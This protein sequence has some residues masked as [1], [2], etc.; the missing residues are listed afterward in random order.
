MRNLAMRGRRE[1]IREGSLCSESRRKWSDFDKN[2]IKIR[3]LE[4]EM[5]KRK[6]DLFLPQA[7]QHPP[8]TFSS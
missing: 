7:P 2:K 5:G 3:K 1:Q 8:H 4:L 6:G